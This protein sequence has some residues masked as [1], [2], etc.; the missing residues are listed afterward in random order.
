MGNPYLKIRYKIMFFMPTPKLIHSFSTSSTQILVKISFIDCIL[1][2]ISQLLKQKFSQSDKG[3]VIFNPGV[4]GWS[5]G[6]GSQNFLKT[7]LK[8]LE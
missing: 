1:L 4:R 5:T 3:L 6:E 2:N 7:C 8:G